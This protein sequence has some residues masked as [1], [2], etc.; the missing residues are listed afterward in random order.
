MGG[1][2]EN[3]EPLSVDKILT[4]SGEVNKEGSATNL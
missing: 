4:R 3:C 1:N 2:P